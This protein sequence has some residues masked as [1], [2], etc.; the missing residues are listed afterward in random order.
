MCQQRT[1][2]SRR[3]TRL[4]AS[5]KLASTQKRPGR[6]AMP[7]PSMPI[8][9]GCLCGAIRYEASEPPSSGAICHCRVCQKTTGSAFH[10]MAM[11]PRTAFRFIK[12]NPKRYRSSSIMEK[13]FCPRCGSTL[14]DQYL[15][16]F[17]TSFNPDIMCVYVGT[18]D[19]PEVMP[20]AKRHFGVESQLSWVHFNDGL[21]RVRCDEDPELAAAFAAAEAGEN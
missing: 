3:S 1:F 12:G 6:I 19:R 16:R 9:G 2:K 21:P 7:Q 18:L 20:L 15:V 11:F 4:A 17:S 8:T 5:C 13:R 14:T 10:A